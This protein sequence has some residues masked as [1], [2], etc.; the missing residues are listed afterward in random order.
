MPAKRT[1]QPRVCEYCGKVFEVIPYWIAIG[2]G[3]FCGKRCSG[4]AHTI[5]PVERF[6]S[7]VDKTPTCWI[8]TAG[9]NG[10][11]YGDFAV[12]KTFH[13]LTHRFSWVLHFGEI[14]D[15]LRV[16][17]H[18]DNPPCV[19]PDHLFLGTARDNSQDMARKERHTS[20]LTPTIV[21][22]I[23]ARY[24][25]GRETYKQIAD[26]LGI[27]LSTVGLIVRRRHWTHI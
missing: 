27:N 21:L 13:Q 24:A 4:K 1:R 11:G 10:M 7:R 17:H 6:W 26:S 3:R 12:S 22:S 18:C 5:P 15:G 25:S 9:T 2:G 14:P 20:H 8:W 16:C 19:R 23:R